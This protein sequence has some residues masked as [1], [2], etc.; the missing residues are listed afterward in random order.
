MV[1]SLQASVLLL[2]AQ[3]FFLIV[4]I[5]F[6]LMVD[7]GLRHSPRQPSPSQRKRFS[8]MIVASETAD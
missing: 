3:E 1:R 5:G 8:F 2:I 7:S 6:E 4:L